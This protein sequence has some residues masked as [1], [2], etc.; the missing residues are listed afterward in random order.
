MKYLLDT[1]VFLWLQSDPKRLGSS[2]SRLERPDSELLVSAASGWE[3]AIKY[4]I[5]RL[6]LPEP[7]ERYVP[8]RVKAIGAL[9]LPV[10]LRHA[11]AV[12]TLPP[13]HRD[14]F[15]RILLCQAKATN[16]I[17]VTAD[18]TMDQYSI[19]TLLIPS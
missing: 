3:I 7:P 1:H 15:D 18:E 12:S 17:L 14:P 19:R 2:I 13:I 11:L 4:E 16:A 8:S 10:E 6:S 9:A 5:G